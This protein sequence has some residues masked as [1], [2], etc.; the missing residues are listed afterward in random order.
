M[1]AGASHPTIQ[2]RRDQR[3]EVGVRS[4]DVT[5]LMDGGV[6]LGTLAL[7]IATFVLVRRTRQEVEA[8]REAVEVTRVSSLERGS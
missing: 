1:T 4:S 8:T 3:G 6:A 2:H 7:A 5:T